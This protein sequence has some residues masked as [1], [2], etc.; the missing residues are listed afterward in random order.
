MSALGR[1]D[2]ALGFRWDMGTSKLTR[3]EDFLDMK[4]F[5][6]SDAD[7]RTGERKALGDPG[8]S[9]E[10]FESGT[11]GD[12]GCGGRIVKRLFVSCFNSDSIVSSRTRFEGKMSEITDRP[13]ENAVRTNSMSSHSFQFKRLSLKLQR[14]TPPLNSFFSFKFTLF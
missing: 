14:R 4:D 10:S 6:G 9:E 8:E 12:L 3:R 7:L 13:M 5:S 2:A 1:M 11:I